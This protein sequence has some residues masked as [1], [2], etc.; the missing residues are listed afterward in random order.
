MFKDRQCGEDGFTG[1][2]YPTAG[3]SHAQMVDPAVQFSGPRRITRVPSLSSRLSEWRSR[4]SSAL[5]S[6]DFAPDLA[7][8]IGS[9]RWLRGV[10]TLIGL[11]ALAIG[12]WPGFSPVE[13]AP[14]MR[15]DDHVRDEFRSQMIMP[16]ALGA[17]SGRHMGAT[18]AV[19]ELANA[20]ERPSLALVATLAQGD[21]FDRMLQ[22]AGVGRE[23]ANQI[24]RMI[25]QAVPIS[26]IDPGTQVDIT[27]GRRTSPDTP[28]PVDA[29][30]FRARFDLQL[31][32]ERQHGAPGARSAPDH[33]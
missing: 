10:A 12:A 19:A 13:A 22:R 33:G 7:R 20:P 18:F 29:L 4:A 25:A 16:L 26:D 9:R 23:E 1:G 24:A 32:V 11:S 6:I 5:S 28:R 2:G 21:G 14:A 3:L 17:D 30:S 8:D 15:I 31:V 27:L